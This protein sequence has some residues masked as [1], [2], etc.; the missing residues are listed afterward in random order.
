MQYMVYFH[1]AGPNNTYCTDVYVSE[2]H[3][4]RSGGSLR[5]YA[6][7][8][9]QKGTEKAYAAVGDNDR[10]SLQILQVEAVPVLEGRAKMPDWF[11]QI[12]NHPSVSTSIGDPYPYG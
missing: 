5:S 2:L 12:I 10:T 11:A 4:E 8:A 9:V 7:L 6:N 3:G 1:L